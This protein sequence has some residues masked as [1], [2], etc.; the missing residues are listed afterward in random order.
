M[1][2]LNEFK[3]VGVASLIALFGWLVN[4]L[5]LLTGMSHNSQLI[6]LNTYTYYRALETNHTNAEILERIPVCVLPLCVVDD[7]EQLEY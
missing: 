7:C 4:Q 3:N 2:K 1:T 5:R 6:E